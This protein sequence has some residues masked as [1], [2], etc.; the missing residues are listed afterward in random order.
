M[1]VPRH[2]M[3]AGILLGC[4]ALIIAVTICQAKPVPW[5]GRVVYVVDGDSII[6]MRGRK[7]F[8]IRL[9]AIDAPEYNQPGGRKAAKH[10]RK[11]LGKRVRVLTKDVDRHGRLVAEVFTADGTN[12]GLEMVRQGLARW[13]RKYAPEAVEYK[14]AGR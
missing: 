3:S 9:W 5:W 7:P 14:A 12:W 6:V 13:Y 4:L 11:L 1:I 2:R 10:T 8:E